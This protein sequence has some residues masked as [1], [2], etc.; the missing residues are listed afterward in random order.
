MTDELTIPLS[1]WAHEQLVGLAK[2]TH[3]PE[4]AALTGATLLGERAGLNGFSLPGRTSAGGGS[5][6]FQARDGW[7]T[8]NLAR[9]DDRDLLPALFCDADADFRREEA[10]AQVI[11][12]CE[13][14]PLVRRGRE[15]GL[16]IA[17]DREEL[18][19]PV[20]Q[21]EEEGRI[22][23][24]RHHPPL[25][26]DLSGLWAGPLSSHLLGLAGA[27]VVK[28]ESHRRTDSMRTGDKALFTLLNQGKDSVMVD[29]QD[30]EDRDALLKLLRL[31]DIVV[32]AARPR[33]LR[34]LGIDAAAL[35]REVP[36]LVWLSITGHGAVGEA[37]NWVGFGD[38]CG[39]AGGLTRALYEASGKIG[40]VGDAI[41]DPLT[42]ILA[43]RTAWER[44]TSGK[45]ARIFLSMSGIVAEALA[46]ERKR[47]PEGLEQSFRNWAASNGQPFPGTRSRSVGEV[48]PLGSD[49]SLWLKGEAAC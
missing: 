17:A 10:I 11:S 14:L 23:S 37:A 12:Q 45:G 24:V 16:A 40:F 31:A 26:I 44:W 7:V 13:C 29:L 47:D 22:S 30:A 35:V 38:D 36:G 6:L 3:S 20:I 25:V 18:L 2:A 34:Q 19:S 46:A 1:N 28:V 5:R 33:A 15:M 8:L 43:A 48:H 21:I 32:E 9:P 42:G 4:V 39:V 41:A 27:R 49:T